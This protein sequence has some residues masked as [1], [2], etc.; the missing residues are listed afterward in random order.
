M[1]GSQY[2]VYK[3]GLEIFVWE[4]RDKFYRFAVEYEYTIYKER[5]MIR[6]LDIYLQEVEE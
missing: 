1:L 6:I 5:K 4:N 2:P 3:K